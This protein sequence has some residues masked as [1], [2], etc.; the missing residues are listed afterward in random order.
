MYYRLI[1]LFSL[2]I[3]SL[4]AGEERYPVESC[5]AYNNLKHTKNTHNV[6]LD[7][8]SAYSIL[9]KH[10]GQYLIIVKGE[11]PAQR[12]VDERCFDGQEE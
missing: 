1:I 4:F 7:T 5:P 10:K 3:S 8:Q 12:W 11:N 2:L 6:T 9:R